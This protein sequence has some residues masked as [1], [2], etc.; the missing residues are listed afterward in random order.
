[1]ERKKTIFI[2]ICSE[3]ALR[4]CGPCLWELFFESTSFSLKQDKTPTPS[5]LFNLKNA[6]IDSFCFNQ[7]CSLFGSF[8]LIEPG[9]RIRYFY[10]SEQGCQECDCVSRQ[11]ASRDIQG[12]SWDSDYPIHRL[13]STMHASERKSGRCREIHSR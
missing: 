3:E 11:G 1:M 12:M 6:F 10:D 2:T 13:S 4:R 9:S 5:S 7:R 8:K